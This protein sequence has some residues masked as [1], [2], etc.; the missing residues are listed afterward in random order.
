M[1]DTGL[2]SGAAA[3]GRVPV[4]SGGDSDGRASEAELGPK[5]NVREVEKGGCE[6]AAA[7]EG[8]EK[9]DQCC[10]LGDDGWRPYGISCGR[11]HR[12][13]PCLPC[14]RQEV[15]AGHAAMYSMTEGQTAKQ[16][17]VSGEGGSW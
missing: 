2:G 6:A 16:G 3:A 9:G 10:R 15:R 17:V 4:S 5:W 13:R 14:G 1:L 12:G 7:A 8:V 11:A